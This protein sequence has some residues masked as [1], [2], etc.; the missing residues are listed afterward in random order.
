MICRLDFQ[1]Y[2]WT[3]THAILVMVI[4]GVLLSL[5][6]WYKHRTWMIPYC[7][8]LF[9]FKY[10]DV[11]VFSASCHRFLHNSGVL[12]ILQVRMPE[13]MLLDE[14]LAG[15]GV[16]LCLVWI[17]LHVPRSCLRFCSSFAGFDK[18][19]GNFE[20]SWSRLKIYELWRRWRS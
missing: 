16:E 5:F 6:S 18:H 19:F 1:A 11:S 2:L 7:M 4:N 13:I 8:N 17:L 20:R 3:W 14:P 10:T 15:L 9:R 12:F